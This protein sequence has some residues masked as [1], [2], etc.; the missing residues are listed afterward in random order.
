MNKFILL[1]LSILLIVSV[2]AGCKA[3]LAEGK[4]N[5][6]VPLSDLPELCDTAAEVADKNSK[7]SEEKIDIF[8]AE[9]LYSYYN[10]DKAGFCEDAY[11]IVEK[12]KFNLLDDFKSTL[13]SVDD[14]KYASF[15]VFHS[16]LIT[17]CTDYEMELY[18]ISELYD[19]ILDHANTLS[20]YFYDR[21]L[22][23]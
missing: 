17:W 14:A 6:T 18:D 12:H 9:L 13:K 3:N 8:M 23:E 1:T 20:R 19:D 7:A 10:K 2:F 4:V 21:N 15:A 5:S 16:R 22:F 11:E